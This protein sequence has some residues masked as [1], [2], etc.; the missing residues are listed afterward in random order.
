M[1]TTVESKSYRPLP[2]TPRCTCAPTLDFFIPAEEGEPN[3]D[4]LALRRLLQLGCS[5]CLTPNQ[6]ELTRLRYTE[7]MTITAIAKRMGVAPSSVSRSLRASREK[8]YR[9]TVE[10]G[11]IG[12]IC[13]LLR[14]QLN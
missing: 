14:R 1:I 7:G 2:R 8:L 9:F 3:S 6:Q 12:Q 10:A 5:R 4:R 11:E 13:D